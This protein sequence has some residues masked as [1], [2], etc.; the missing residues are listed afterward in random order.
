M[1]IY[2]CLYALMGLIVIIATFRCENQE[3]RNKICG[4]ASFCLI[5]ALVALRHENMGEDLLKEVNGEDVGYLRAYEVL[6]KMPWSKILLFEG[7]QNYE[8]GY[9]VLN[10]LVYIAC[11]GQQQA[12]LIVCAAISL[13]PIAIL[14]TK[15][16]PSPVF[17]FVIYMGLPVFLIVF[18]GLRQAIAVG[19]CTL[20]ILAIQKRKPI[21][22]ALLVLLATSFHYSAWMFFIAYPAY[23]LRMRFPVRV[24]TAFF[25]PFVFLMRRPLFQT[26][27]VLLKDDAVMDNNNAL[28]LFLIF[29]AI[30]F[31][32]VIFMDDSDE[33]NG[34]LNLFF[35][36]CICQAF[37]GIYGT[38]MRVG[39][40]FMTALPILLPS[41]IKGMK[42]E[43]DRKLMNIIT[44]ACFALFAIYT[45]AQKDSYA[46]TNPYLFFWE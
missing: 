46:N 24:A 22:F 6:G 31:F 37:S 33:Q 19:I 36:T 18:S 27:S 3:T 25:I 34:Y 38:A 30:Y 23:Y 44:V 8:I 7:F 32:C 45:F 15:R 12:L 14:Y 41:T 29:F 1:T 42:K 43:Q 20:S 9:A 28:T 39:Y 11:F 17:S 21:V 26:L 5:F 10:K 13:L 4:W 35:L 2:F 16:S 40:Y